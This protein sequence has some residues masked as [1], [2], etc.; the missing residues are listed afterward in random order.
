MNQ[1]WIDRPVYQAKVEQAVAQL[2]T[3]SHNL[4][5]FY[6]KSGI[7]KTGLKHRLMQIWSER[8]ACATVNGSGIERHQFP[9]VEQAT[10]DLRR[11]LGKAEVK[12]LCFDIAVAYYWAIAHPSTAFNATGFSQL[13]GVTDHVST[14]ADLVS[15]L[16]SDL[17]KTVP[18]VGTASKLLWL[19]QRYSQ[20]LLESYHQNHCDLSQIEEITDP[21]DLLDR[22]PPL[23]ASQLASVLQQQHCPAIVMIDGYEGLVKPQNPDWLV[24]LMQHPN[25]WLLWI[26]FAERPIDRIPLA[27]QIEM[28]PL[29]EA[30]SLGWLQAMGIEEVTLRSTLADLCAGSPLHLNTCREI[31]EKIAPRLPQ[32]EDFADT[33][34]QLFNQYLTLSGEAIQYAFELLAWVRVWDPALLMDLLTEFHPQQATQAEALAAHLTASPYVE[35]IQPGRWQLNPLVQRILQSQQQPTTRKNQQIWLYHYYQAACQSAIEQQQ[36]QVA[37]Q[38]MEEAL[39]HAEGAGLLAEAVDWTVTM[40]SGWF[41]HQQERA[42]ILVALADQPIDPL[43]QAQVNSLLGRLWKE[44]GQGDRAIPVLEQA[45]AQWQSLQMQESLAAAAVEFDLAE[46]Y[47][48][49]DRVFDAG[50]AADWAL[51]YRQNQPDVPAL[52]IADCFDQQSRIA[53]AQ[54]NYREAMRWNQEALKQYES[55]PTLPAVKLAEHCLITAEL[56]LQS[57]ADLGQA[58]QFCLTALEKLDAAAIT[59]AASDH[60]LTITAHGLLGNIYEKW[61][62]KKWQSAFDHYQQ[63]LH[64]SETLL[65]LSHPQTLLYLRFLARLSRKMSNE[66]A[67]QGF[68][69][70]LNAQIAVGEGQETVETAAALSRIGYALYLKGEYGKA[71]PL[72]LWALRIRRS[73]LGQDHPDTAPSLNNLAELYQSQG[74]YG[75]AEPLLLQALDIRRTQLGQDHP[76]TATSLNNLAGL[77]KSQGRY[78]EAEPLYVQALDIIRSQLGQAHPYTAT[79]LNNLAE[80]YLSQGRYSETE[81]LYVQALD[82]NRSQL[83]QDH[84][85]T[86]LSLNNLAGLYKSQE[87]YGEAEPLYLQA[88]TIL[89]QKLG[90]DHPNTKTAWQNFLYCLQQAIATGQSDR[91]SDHPITQDLLKQLTTEEQQA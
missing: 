69:E 79:S 20:P 4:L 5:V 65:D 23:L 49:V 60:P 37:M 14:W 64:L 3:Q 70:R 80:L 33:A 40:L 54:G 18:Y 89:V 71:E 27:Q 83:G 15:S 36:I 30:E 19:L 11:S 6:G 29:T 25:P 78:G 10:L 50:K 28:Q 86:A 12:L 9:P 58:A 38:V 2:G 72:W 13:E 82:I 63:A 31:C 34:Q 84:P 22:L 39:Y 55:I 85:D 21:Y 53:A 66:T 7:G 68:I 77:Y 87:R 35:S 62:A 17:Q 81:P 67:A 90:V 24:D 26:V 45:R 51:S 76:D 16:A 47:L 46:V 74:R 8:H 42:D 75:E 73:Q 56:Y 59:T 91:L 48:S 44:L 52:D 43:Q 57:G 88:L 61:G 1:R 41:R 32:F